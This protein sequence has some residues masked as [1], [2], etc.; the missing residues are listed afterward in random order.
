VAFLVCYSKKPPKDHTKNVAIY[1]NQKLYELIFSE[2]MK[3]DSEYVILMDIAL[4]KY[5]DPTLVV[6]RKQLKVLAQELAHLETSNKDHP[7]VKEFLEI[8]NKAIKMKCAL[9]IS[10]D[11][12]PEL[13]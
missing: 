2:S 3:K 12:Y 4:L 10:G 7:Q 8:C 9:T 5:K 11:M 6:T 13:Y 1:L